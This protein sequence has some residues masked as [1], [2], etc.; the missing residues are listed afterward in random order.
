MVMACLSSVAVS[1]KI[2]DAPVADDTAATLA[3]I[4]DGYCTWG[5]GM[6]FGK[7]SRYN[8]ASTADT[9]ASEASTT[10]ITGIA[11]RKRFFRSGAC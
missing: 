8:S 5:T 9:K 2:T 1:T 7:E 4:L 3:S 6:G 10:A 11:G